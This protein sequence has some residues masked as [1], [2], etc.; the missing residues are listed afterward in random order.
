MRRETK[1]AHLLA[2]ARKVFK[3]EEAGLR[4]TRRALGQ[5]FLRAVDRLK[6]IRGRVIVIGV[7]KSGLIGRKLAATLTS[8]GTSAIF[9]HP[10]EALHGDLGLVDGN[11]A[12]LALSFSGETEELKK[13]LPFLRRLKIPI[14][15]ITGYRSSRLAKESDVTL[16]APVRREACPYNITPTASATAMLALGDALAMALMKAKGFGRED[17]ARFHPGGALGRRLNLLVEDVMRRGAANPIVREAADVREALFVMT[18]TRSGAAS[19]V[20]HRGR[21]AGFFTDG[22]LRRYLHRK[23]K[24]R[25]NGVFLLDRP[26]RDVMTKKPMALSPKATLEDAAR[27]FKNKNFD[28]AP[29]VDGRGFPIGLID[30]RDLLI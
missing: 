23:G 24:E 4:V 10:S 8:T 29:V 11:D 1:T 27:L 14:V 5:D 25:E 9:M 18:K 19:V 2:L 12:V 13:L 16:D 15:A 20:D 7:G 6:N 30:E 3:I 26:V 22:D 21:L 17:F 28:N